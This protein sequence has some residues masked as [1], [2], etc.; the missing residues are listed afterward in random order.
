[1]GEKA[2]A[3]GGGGGGGEFSLGVSQGKQELV[4]CSP[5]SVPGS[6]QMLK[7]GQI[8]RHTGERTETGGAAAGAAIS[9][10]S[11]ILTLCRYVSAPLPCCSSVT[12][13]S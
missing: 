2:G 3:G 13:I 12:G 5:G 9:G 11:A 1:M 4:G 6:H 10:G 7:T 8:D